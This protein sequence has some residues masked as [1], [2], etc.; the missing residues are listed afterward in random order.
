[1]KS[2]DEKENLSQKY[3]KCEMKLYSKVFSPVK[4]STAA[5]IEYNNMGKSVIFAQITK[6]K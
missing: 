6:D 1:M 3:K 4:M 2:N 5:Y